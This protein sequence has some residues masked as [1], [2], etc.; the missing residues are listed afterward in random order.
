MENTIKSLQ[1]EKRL[2]EKQNRLKK[3]ANNSILK[4][5]A[6]AAGSAVGTV[7]AF[8]LALPELAVIGAAGA[9][10]ATVSSLYY[11]TG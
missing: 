6:I 8:S 9:V 1:E 5:I 3:E 10:F 11:A 7:A 4:S 2:E